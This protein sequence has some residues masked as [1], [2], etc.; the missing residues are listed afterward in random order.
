M[1]KEQEKFRK[2]LMAYISEKGYIYGPSPMIYG[3][4]AGFYDF[5]PL[6]KTLKE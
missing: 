2:E 3:G 6:G 4:V 5:G 1:A